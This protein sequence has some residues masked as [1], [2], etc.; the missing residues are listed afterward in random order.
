VVVTN[1]HG[2]AISSNAVLTVL[3]PAAITGQPSSQAVLLNSNATLT[4]T[5]IGT[6]PLSRRWYFNGTPL[7]DGGRVSGSTT[8]SLNISNVQTN[9]GGSYQ[10]VVTNICGSATSAVAMLMV[11]V[12]AGITGQPS[13]QAVLLNSNVTF[14]ATAIGT[15]PLFYLWQKDGLNLANGGRISGADTATLTLS[16]VQTNDAGNYR[17]VVTNNYG[18]ATSVVATLTV[19]LP[20]IIT[21]QPTSQS[22][23]LNSNASFSASAIGD[24]PL[25]FQWYFNG[26]PLTDGGRVSGSATTNLTIANV[27]TNDAGSYQLVVTN[28]YGTATSTSATLT[29]LVPAAITSQPTNRVVLSGSNVAFTV[30]A[31]GTAPLNYLWY[32]N[33]TVLANG[34]RISGATTATLNISSVQTNDSAS[35]QVIVTNNFS[36]ATSFVATL[37]VLAPVKIISHPASQAVLLGSNASFT[38]TASGTTPG[39]QWYFNG[40]PLSDGGRISGSAAPTL[41]IAN[42]QSSDSG[43]YVAV[44]TNLLSTATS[45][46][47]LLTPLISFDPSVH[48]VDLNSPNPVSP[49]VSWSTAATNI[50]NAIDAASSG[51]VVWVT[52]GVY[53]TGGKLVPGSYATSRVAVDKPLTVVS[54]NGP[55]L[56]V[57]QGGGTGRSPA[58][59]AYLT[60]G[61]ILAGFTLTNGVVNT[62]QL[63]GTGLGGGVYCQ[64]S[65]AQLTSCIL[66]GNSASS[67]GG[68]Y[69]GTLNNCAV[70]GNTATSG[71]G[72]FQCTLNNCTLTGNSASSSGGGSLNSTLNNC[73]VYY[74]KAPNG[75]N[76]SGSVLNYCC[77]IPLPVTGTGNFITDPQLASGFHL[78]TASPCRGAGNASYA[79]GNDIDGEV[80][81]NPPSVGCD[82]YWSG[83]ITGLI[84][85]SIAASHTNVTPSYVVALTGTVAGKASASVWDFGDGVQVS[86]LLYASHAW[87]NAGNYP[88]VLTAYNEDYPAGISATQTVQVAAQTIF[89]SVAESVGDFVVIPGFC[90]L[91]LTG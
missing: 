33:G 60:N 20:A 28:S 46:T 27:Q 68:A 56:T 30:S 84:N 55:S 10:L 86:K 17:I 85:V 1:S 43:G 3:V 9:D 66:T 24:A 7:T 19:L 15:A 63:K 76:Y 36:S 69:Q 59:C 13:S 62:E 71:G 74:N 81:A 40:T 83:S 90:K 21:S 8:A 49:Y 6:A 52:N 89:G 88:V 75:S 45:R 32:S 22:V 78:S 58:R 65:A 11:L 51:D 35:Y 77:T 70:I 38:V 48:Y 91:F 23:L 53:Q 14:T 26:T 16:G 42:V 44:V 54:V 79:S 50:Q 72:T 5:A 31:T 82:E 4:A 61:A 47:A 73:I 25:S 39:Y 64:S 2:I 34:G 57:I 18:S 67:G 41:N 37:T 87:A 80:W 29:A 12:P